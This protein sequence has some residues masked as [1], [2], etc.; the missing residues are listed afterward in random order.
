MQI[1]I[2]VKLFFGNALGLDPHPA[3]TSPKLNTSAITG[4]PQNNLFFAIFFSF[5]L[6]TKFSLYVEIHKT[7][8]LRVFCCGGTDAAVSVSFRFYVA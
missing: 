7:G 3:R 6:A 1:I 2:Y 4:V 8:Y 5:T